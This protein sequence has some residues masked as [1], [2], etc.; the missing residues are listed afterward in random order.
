MKLLA[1]ILAALVGLPTLS[2]SF[3]LE[4]PKAAQ[5]PLRWNARDRRFSANIDSLPLKSVMAKLGAATGWKI[6]LDPDATHTVSVAFSD[7]STSEALR[8]LLGGLSFALVP[9]NDGPQKLLIYR[10][11]ISEATELVENDKDKRGKDWL[12]SELIVSIAKG[13]KEEIEAL[14]KELGAK[15]VGRNDKLG[16]YRLQFDSQEAAD[17]AREKLAN[18]ENLRVDDNFSVRNPED[19][20]Y[21][22]NRGA[23]PFNL[24]PDVAPDGSR[25]I[26]AVVDTPVQPLDEERSKFLLPG[27]DVTGQYNPNMPKGSSPWHGTSMV[28]TLLNTLNEFSE[29]NPKSNVRVLPVNVYSPDPNSTPDNPQF[30]QTSTFEVALGVYEAVRNGASIVNLSL[31]G[32][33]QSPYLEDLI[34]QARRRGVLFF[35]AAGNTPTTAPTYPAASPLVF[36]VTA[37]DAT[38]G[39]APYANRGSFIDL[40]APGTSYLEYGGTRFRV[41]GTSPATAYASAVAAASRS[42][43]QTVQ[44]TESQMLSLFGVKR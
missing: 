8:L 40:I 3:E 33:G 29:E 37:S 10:K 25:T 2:A 42:N 22:G 41:S 31:G 7:R 18:K 9:Q 27:V 35:A 14:A 43:G 44:Q 28:E 13:S 39:I 17:A 36:A 20:N 32:D 38:G 12:A 34:M 5:A 30:A 15:I 23:S 26:V 21:V 16:T 11:N 19:F 4:A 24:T 1:C 6:Y